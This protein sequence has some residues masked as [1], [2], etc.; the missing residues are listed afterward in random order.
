MPSI[1]ERFDSDS[2]R[3]AWD[4]AADAYAGFQADGGDYYRL[5]FFGPAQVEACGEVA[6]LRLLDVG[7]GSGYF[8]RQMASR[9]ARVAGIDISAEML[10]HARALEEEAPLGI[11]YR[12]VDALLIGET[13]EP[14]SFDMATSCVALQDMPDIPRVLGGI[15]RALKPGGRFV[16]CIVHPGTDMRHREWV[17]DEHGERIALALGGYFEEGPIEY[18]WAGEKFAYTFATSAYHATMERWFGWYHAA[19]FTLRAYY[20]PKPSAEA[21]AAHPDLLDALLVPYFVIF[22]LQRTA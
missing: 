3:A 19:G 22:D 9:G 6:G 20:E 16:N 5:D 4:H 17:T 11:D 13:F 7:C 1:P 2:V 21:L 10:R 14:A 15:A 18:E 8:S 12:H